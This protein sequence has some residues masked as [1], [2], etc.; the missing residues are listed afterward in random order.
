MKD[1]SS[2]AI[3]RPTPDRMLNSFEVRCA[4]GRPRRIRR[5]GQGAGATAAAAAGGDAAESHRT[6]I[7]LAGLP[8]LGKTTLARSWQRSGRPLRMSSGPAIQHAGDLVVLSSLV[9]GEILFID[10]IHCM[11]RS[12]E[13]MLYLAMGRLSYRHI[14]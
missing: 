2:V 6:I 1:D 10:E 9:P 5:P 4:P 8:G 14:M 3:V 12:A 7:L 11:A 13:E